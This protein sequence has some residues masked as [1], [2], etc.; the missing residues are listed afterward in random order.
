MANFSFKLSVFGGRARFVPDSINANIS[1]QYIPDE[2]KF[3]MKT[4]SKV[5]GRQQ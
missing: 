5:E 1:I 4:E 2:N 3:T